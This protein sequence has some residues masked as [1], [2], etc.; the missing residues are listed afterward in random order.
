MKFHDLPH[1]QRFELECEPYV[2]IGPLVAS[3]AN[4]GKQRFMARSAM[5]TP[6]GVEAPKPAKQDRAISAAAV[7]AAFDDFQGRC[8]E[9]LKQMEGE[10]PAGKLA[11]AKEAIGTAREKFLK[12]LDKS[13]A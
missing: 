1:G 4:T 13:G 8:L 12:S 3:H 11:T 6:I 9:A 7:L 5:V 2:K 10:V